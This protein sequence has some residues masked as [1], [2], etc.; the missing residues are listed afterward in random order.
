MK[1]IE[2]MRF[3]NIAGDHYGRSQLAQLTADGLSN[4]GLN[5]FQ[6]ININLKTDQVS[7][8]FESL[9]DATCVRAI[10]GANQQSKSKEFHGNNIGQFI[11]NLFFVVPT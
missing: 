3:L 6:H 2:I 9:E 10:A 8:V 4:L 5:S 1:G 11:L 7:I